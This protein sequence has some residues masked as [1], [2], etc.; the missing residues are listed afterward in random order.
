MF[1]LIFDILASISLHKSKTAKRHGQC[2]IG[3]EMA[4]EFDDPTIS[5]RARSST[6]SYTQ[7]TYIGVFFHAA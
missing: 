3:V 7:T 5:K 1:A 2:K 4:K 6:D